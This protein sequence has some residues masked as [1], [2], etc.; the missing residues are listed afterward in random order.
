MSDSNAVAGC[1]RLKI[2]PGMFEAVLSGRKTAEFRTN[3]RGF[4]ASDSIVLEEWNPET[5]S[6]TGRTQEV[7]VTHVVNGPDFGIP[8]GYCMLSIQCVEWSLS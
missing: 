1:H 3:E 6:Y 8:T 7:A 2:W 5:E 4:I